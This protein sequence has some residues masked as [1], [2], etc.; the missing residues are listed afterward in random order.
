MKRRSFLALGGSLPGLALCQDAGGFILSKTGCGRATGYAE[1][2]KI[3]T[4]D[5]KTHAAWLD[6]AEGGFHV[7]IRTLDLATKA[8][9]ETITVGGAVDNHGGPALTID[10][11]GFLH[12]VYG[13]HHHPMRYRRSIRPNDASEW[14]PEV[15]FGEKLT[16]P[17]MVCEAE[18]NLIFTCRRSHTPKPWEMEMWTRPAA[19]DGEWKFERVLARS[20]HLKY[21]HFQEGLAWGPDGETLHL[22]CRF[23]ELTDDKGYGRI[24]NVGY[25]QSP[26]RGRTWRKLNG[27]P[28]ELPATAP[29]VDVLATGGKD[30]GRDLRIGGLAIDAGGKPIVFYSEV[31]GTRGDSFLAKPDENGAWRSTNLRPFVP[32]EFADW[33]LISPGGLVFAPGGELILAAQIYLPEPPNRS[34]W[35][36]PKS[37]ICVLRSK[38]EGRTFSFEL[39]TGPDPEIPS[40]LPNLER[41]TGFNA[42]PNS[43]GMIFTVGGKGEKNTEILSNDV[44]WRP[45]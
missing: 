31:K 44:V 40:W 32:E 37:E 5:G 36:H 34:A 24:Q 2:N 12:I 38:D 9:G 20:R 22:F 25:M 33:N 18:D 8:W 29:D 27:D 17:T 41:P 43:P 14:S 35:G 11:Q 42:V 13:P 21:S 10:R 39:L 1:A 19:A 16:Y 28:I 4:H 26:D 30:V 6:S 23:H 7:R 15:E 3:I 45:I